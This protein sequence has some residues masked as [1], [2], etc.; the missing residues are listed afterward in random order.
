[1]QQLCK[2]SDLLL[3]KMWEDLI[4]QTLHPVVVIFRKSKSDKAGILSDIYFSPTPSPTP[5]KADANLHYACNI[6]AKIKTDCLKI[7]GGVDYTNFLGATESQIG[8][9][10]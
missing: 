6:R 5:S 7:V 8:T 1:M 2:V 10:K 3:I 4:K 9:T